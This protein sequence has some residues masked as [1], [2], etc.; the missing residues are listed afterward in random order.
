MV[1]PGMWNSSVAT[2]ASPSSVGS[3]VRGPGLVRLPLP[4]EEELPPVTWPC[5]R[6][7][8]VDADEVV[9]NTEDLPAVFASFLGA[10][11][12]LPEENAGG[13]EEEEAGEED[14]EEDK[15][16]DVGLV[17]PEEEQPLGLALGRADKRQEE[18][19]RF[20]GV[21]LVREGDHQPLPQ[22][23]YHQ[24]RPWAYN[25]HA[26]PARLRLRLRL[27]RAGQLQRVPAG[28]RVHGHGEGG[29]RVGQ[30]DVQLAEG[31]VHR[32]ADVHV[33][34]LG[35]HGKED[36]AAR[37]QVTD[38][39]LVVAV[40]LRR[41][42]KAI[43]LLHCDLPAARHSHC[44][45]EWRGGMLVMGGELR[46]GSLT[47]DVWVYEP[48]ADQ[49]RR[50]QPLS[51]RNPPGLASHAAALVDGS[52][53]VYGGRT[54]E[55]SFSGTM[56]RL[57][58]QR[59]E[60]EEV[61]PTGGKSPPVAAHSMVFH[62][63][64]RT[65]LIHGGHRLS[66]RFSYRTNSTDIFHV[67]RRYWSSLAA[68]PSAAGPRERAFHTA[69]LVG[70]YMVVYGG[71]VHIHYQEEKCYDDRIFFYHLGCHQWVSGQELG[72]LINSADGR[73][74]RSRRGRYSHVAALM[75]GNVLL[76]AGGFSGQSLGDL[77]AYKL[78][79]FVS[80]VMVQNV[81]V[82]YCSLYGAEVTCSKDPECVWCQSRCQSY[83]PH[84]TCP[85]RGCL[86]LSGLLTDCQSCLVFG[87]SRGSPPHTPGALGWCVQ[88]ATCLPV[89]GTGHLPI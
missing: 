58:L 47:S 20:Q 36:G 32:D 27:A 52:L 25:R 54:E 14:T 50:L 22:S 6:A 1:P 33:R 73:E 57:D 19:L 13:Q 30:V 68:R 28:Q 23:P 9:G 82:D 85:Q 61:L 44:G 26:L 71:N 80:H 40:T 64:S 5:R 15:E 49:W 53:Y 88:T 3:R 2:A 45:L 37:R 8:A 86:G 16:V 83:Q 67:D 38:P 65:L 76:V 12:G 55:G 63:Q 21:T 39:R 34:E 87:Q 62:P 17:L 31:H 35:L 66:P 72:L 42:V 11:L 59:L 81:H 4:V 24:H 78:P 43:F 84:S 7:R 60:W 74:G 89:S 41:W 10:L 70:N 77:V 56:F 18:A 69:T 46:N 48:L 75:R 51:S 79:V 29:M